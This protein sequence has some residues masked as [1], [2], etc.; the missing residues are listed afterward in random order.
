MAHAGGRDMLAQ[1]DMF[2]RK[3]FE[4]NVTAHKEPLVKYGVLM[5][6]I[7][8]SA[9]LDLQVCCMCVRVYIYVYIHIILH[10][11]HAQNE[12]SY[13]D[14]QLFSMHHGPIAKFET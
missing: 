4:N 13:E 3:A 2:A 14:L 12:K 1:A 6:K 5:H 9:E 10:A 7:G 8:T 11:A